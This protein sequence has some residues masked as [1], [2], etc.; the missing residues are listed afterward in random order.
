MRPRF[1]RVEVFGRVRDVDR[2]RRLH[3]Q[4]VLGDILAHHLARARHRAEADLARPDH[5][6]GA[7]EEDPPLAQQHPRGTS[8]TSDAVALSPRAPTA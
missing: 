6:A 5:P 7:A 1:G 4:P 8:P 2:A 3:H